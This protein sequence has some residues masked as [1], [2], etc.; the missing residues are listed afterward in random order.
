MTV[1]Q[2][3][4]AVAGEED[5]SRFIVMGFDL[6]E[7]NWVVQYDFPIFMMHVFEYLLPDVLGGVKDALSGDVIPLSLHSRAASAQ[8]LMP[9]GQ[10]IPLAPPFPVLPLTDTQETG[11]Y[12]LRQTLPEGETIDT[13]FAVN[14]PSGESD[15]RLVSEDS[16]ANQQQAGTQSYGLEWTAFLILALLLLSMLE[17]WV[18]VRAN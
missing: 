18:S 7:S 12:T 13:R 15:V 8:V 16:G 3:A 10:V 6:H 14:L 1:G 5:G 11:V 2:D 17:W 9:S 4:A